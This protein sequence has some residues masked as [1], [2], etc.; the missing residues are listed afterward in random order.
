MGIVKELKKTRSLCPQCRES[1]PAVV[2]Q[3]G[4]EV[5]L[6]K[7]CSAHGTF[8]AV[9]SS[10]AKHYHLSIGSGD[11]KKPEQNQLP[12]VSETGCG[13]GCCSSVENLST[14]VGFIEIVSSC[15]LSCPVCFADSPHK[16]HVDALE[17]SEFVNRVSSVIDRKGAIDILQLSGG[18]PTIHPEFFKLL[19]WAL[20]HNGIGHVLLNTN[21]VRLTNP[22]FFD[23]LDNLRDLF[24]K[25]EIYLQFDGLQAAGQKELRGVDMRKTRKKVVDNCQAAGIPVNLAMTVDGHNREHLGDVLKFA[26]E[27]PG[28]SGVTWQPMFGSGRAY[29]GF[30]LEDLTGSPNNGEVNATVQT[31]T[32]RRLNVADII[33]GVV[34]QS[35]GLVA[36]KDF[37]PLP[38]GDPNCHTVAYLLRG[39]EGL[40]GLASLIDLESVQGFLKDRLNYDVQ[41]LIQCG[42]ESE[43]LGHILKQLEIGEDSVL[44]LVIKPFM[45]VWTYDQHRVD[46][47]CVHVIGPGGSLQSFCQHYAMA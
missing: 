40:T 7:Q 23:Q 28:I 18:E 30:N 42:C 24:G 38:C 32:M 1:I 36:E 4:S 12:I 47:C 6:E 44:R 9:I 46:R 19:G 33:T 27:N 25:L 45:D 10:D 35:D 37:T 2:I 3:K 16:S 31:P 11:E 26:V 22:E 43:P 8:S 5:F 29:D 21:G 13:S 20:S 17:F 39:P 14:C 34:S 41:D 15:N